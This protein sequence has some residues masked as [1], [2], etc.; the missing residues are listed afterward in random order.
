M[1]ASNLLSPS[2]PTGRY[3]FEIAIF[4][5]LPLE[6]EAVIALFDK[7][8][9]DRA[10]GK[11]AGDS[12][13]YSLG[14][15]GD[16]NVVLAHL[17]NMGKIAAAT[18]AVFLYTSYENIKLAM[19]VGICGGVPSGEPPNGEILLGDVVISDGIIQYDFGKKSI[20]DDLPR[21]SVAIRTF[22]AKL[23]MSRSRNQLREK[24]LEHLSILQRELGNRTTYPGASEDRLFKPEY[25]HK[26]HN[27]S[28]CLT[29]NSKTADVCNAALK[30]SCDQLGCDKQEVI[31]RAR[32]T[33]P[34]DTPMIHFG[35]I[36]SGDLVMKSGEDRDRLASKN[37]LIAFEMEGAGLWEIFPNCLIIKSVC[38]YADSH[39][40]KKWQDYAAAVAASA[41]K[42]VLENWYTEHTSRLLPPSLPVP[43]ATDTMPLDPVRRGAI[44]KMLHTSPYR[45]RKERNPDRYPGT[46]EWF[47][48]HES[49]RRWRDSIS[50]S[51]LWVSAY[52]GCGKSVLAKHLVDSELPT[53][54]L[55][56][57]CYFFFNNDFPDQMSARSA[58]CCILHQLFKQRGALLSDDI[59]ERF[60]TDGDHLTE[61]FN[62][63]WDVLVTA[64]Q[65]ENAGEIVCILDAFDECEDQE[66]T[67]FARY[68]SKF[69]GT[70]N[71]LNLKFLLT[72]R[73]YVDIRQ[74][75]Q[76]LQIPRLPII[77]LSGESNTEVEQISK[78]ID[79]YI[80][81]R[82]RYIGEISRLDPAEEQQ[83][84]QGLLGVHNR[85]Y[86]WARLTLD[87]IQNNI[88]VDKIS[89]QDA[90]SQLP[91]TVDHAYE[92]ILARSSD[93]EKAK[94]LLHII[95]AAVRPL[96]LAEMQ[97]ALSLR[98]SDLS[99]QLPDLKLEEHFL[100]YV[101]EL[102]G[103]FITIIDSKIYLLHQT[104][105]EFLT[106][107]GTEGKQNSPNN[108]LKGRS[109][110]ETRKSHRIL[111]RIRI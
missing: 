14:T 25:Q 88:G 66:R 33:S 59:V 109:S 81:S 91:Q 26:H 19:V 46:C 24:A 1:M 38:D 49:F 90:M 31:T 95:I 58:I 37:G 101:K 30:L 8:W 61:S 52:P 57:T 55:R 79:I 93:P 108:H 69:Y 13:T 15:I 85:T 104:A 80:E 3:D 56:T 97:F 98:E 41:T 100:K 94:K 16:H 77:R 34:S 9:D 83:L 40:S 43:I 18:T 6:A 103:L 84:L 102:C 7:H 11:A 29:C 35:L 50:S 17:P 82:V 51:M 42:A 78:E 2:P 54:K 22:L 76:P 60:E 107:S 70:K 32:L 12:N 28:K 20:L 106:Q 71:S 67:E 53:T 99:Y 23:Q 64:S 68:L 86:L 73:P 87:I 92:S 105:K 63:L 21:P 65:N 96:T 111:S 89:T 74:G 75:F 110:T 4:C 10:Y 36:A 44:L 39:K 45:D 5:A 47:V 62:E 72:S 27:P 48:T